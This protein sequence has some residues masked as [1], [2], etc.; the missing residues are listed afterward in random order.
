ML[1]G[2]DKLVYFTGDHDYQVWDS[3]VDGI[4]CICRISDYEVKNG[5]TVEDKVIVVRGRFTDEVED[6]SD[7]SGPRL[8]P[9]RIEE[10]SIRRVYTE[11]DERKL[12]A[13]LDRL[14]QE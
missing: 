2:Q 10:F 6:L 12:L 4:K 5:Y 9:E 13:C 3:V 1:V 11:E 7:D 14:K 8:G